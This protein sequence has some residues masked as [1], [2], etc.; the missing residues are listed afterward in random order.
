MLNEQTGMRRQVLVVDDEAVNRQL[1]G[2]IVSRDY[3][4]LY[5]ENG[6]KALEI[7]QEKHKTLSLVLLDLLMPEASGYEVLEVMRSSETLKRIPVIVLTSEKEAEIRSLQLG[8]VD[9]IAKPYDMP[10]IILARVQ[11]SIELAEDKTIIQEARTDSLTGLYS[12]SFFYQYASQFDRYYP[13][14]PMDAVVVD[15]NRFHLLNE[16]YGRPVCDELLKNIA[17]LMLG[18]LDGTKGI[19]CRCDSDTFYAY[20]VHHD[21]HDQIMQQY[22]DKLAKLMPEVKHS[23]RVGIYQNV[24]TSLSIEQRFDRASLACTKLRGTYSSG[25]SLYDNDLQEK[26]LY[27]EKLI[28]DMDRALTE[29]QFVVYYQ[30]KYNIQGDTPVLTSAEALIRWIHP[31]YGMVSPGAFIPLFEENG[32]INKLDRYVWREAA[33]QIARWK[34]LYGRTIPVSVNVSRIDIYDPE[35]LN[36]LI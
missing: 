1:L 21:D 16:I 26:E 7:I 30:P 17:R 12:K 25:Y 13:D 3:D 11:R 34:E 20:F 33:A 23:V 35:L 4:V 10:D 9:F 31:D 27:S 6:R 19:A 15:I 24:D 18:F 36:E 22:A 28:M 5:A 8:A 29:K 2:F 32:L 14:M